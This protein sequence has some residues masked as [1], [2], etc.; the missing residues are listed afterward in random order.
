MGRACPIISDLLIACLDRGIDI[1]A[2]TSFNVAGDPIV[3]DQFD[4]Y[5]NMHQM[6]IEFLLSDDGLYRLTP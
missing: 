3:F 5:I 4:A 1:L 2:N 6:G